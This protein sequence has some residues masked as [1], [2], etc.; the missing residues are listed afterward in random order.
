MFRPGESAAMLVDGGKVRVDG[1]I[2]GSGERDVTMAVE[3]IAPNAARTLRRE[4]WRPRLVAV[5]AM[6]TDA[7]NGFDSALDSPLWLDGAKALTE[8]LR[9]VRALIDGDTDP[10]EGL[11]RL[12]AEDLTLIESWMDEPLDRCEGDGP[13]RLLLDRLRREVGA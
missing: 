1:V 12:D 8:A 3:A 7:E 13:A 9:E 10:T 4:G 5:E 2:I 11:V 6:L